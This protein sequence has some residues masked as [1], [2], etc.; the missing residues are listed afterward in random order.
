MITFDDVLLAST[1]SIEATVKLYKECRYFDGKDMVKVFHSSIVKGNA[2]DLLE[3]DDIAC[4]YTMKLW[5]SIHKWAEDLNNFK[6]SGFEIDFRNYVWQGVLSSFYDHIYQLFGTKLKKE[7]SK[8]VKTNINLAFYQVLN[9]NALVDPYSM[10]S[11]NQIEAVDQYNKVMEVL[12]KI[13]N[14][15][16]N[17]YV[18]VVKAVMDGK[19]CKLISKQ[20]RVSTTTVYSIMKS[21][22]EL[23]D[24]LNA[25]GADVQKQICR[26]V[27]R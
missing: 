6:K 11:F 15:K 17:M 20:L 26:H 2:K 21:C 23:W 8:V 7:S 1:G 4:F 24:E 25:G 22:T 10:D 16:S 18:K 14:K 5:R 19:N 12:G 3:Q 27:T 13:K 9:Y